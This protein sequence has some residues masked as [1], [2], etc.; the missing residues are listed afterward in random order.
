MQSLPDLGERFRRAIEAIDAANA[1]DPE[2]II[3]R[4]ETVPKELTHA[5]MA[6]RWVLHLQP[7][8]SE[9]LLLA[10]RAHHIR[11]WTL[12][13]DSYPRDRTG[14]L[15]WRVRL[16]DIH[17]AEADAILES[18]GYDDE[19]RARV[20]AIV[21][22]RQ[23][24]SDAE[25]QVFEDALAL[26][27]LETQLDETAGKIDDDP[28]TIDV[29]RKTWVKMSPAGQVAALT[30]DLTERGAMLVQAALASISD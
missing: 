17:A 20:G 10:A 14:Y 19:T 2:T 25:V 12:P 27:F 28:K 3:V 30:I 7:Q 9:A 13:R 26:V 4:G 23:L 18:L 24:H 22:K 16:Q 21:H 29:I 11:R 5:R 15:R 8:A 6:C 1:D